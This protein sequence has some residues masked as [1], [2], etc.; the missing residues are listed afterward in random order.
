[1]HPFMIIGG[2]LHATAVAIIAFFVFF[3]ASKSSGLL[4]AF[5]TLLG[6]WLVLLAFGAIA[7]SVTGM[8]GKHMW[9]MHHG[10]GPPP[11]AS[12]PPAAAAS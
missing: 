11:A 8:G 1:M 3:G 9:M 12:T 5:G 6:W 10:E 4:K 7:M 2:L